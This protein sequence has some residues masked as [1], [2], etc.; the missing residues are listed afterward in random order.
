MESRYTYKFFGPFTVAFETKHDSS[1]FD[2]IWS[3][4]V[5]DWNSLTLWDTNAIRFKLELL[6]L[7]FLTVTLAYFIEEY[8]L[9]MLMFLISCI[10][11]TTSIGPPEAVE[12]RF[13]AVIKRIHQHVHSEDGQMDIWETEK[14]CKLDK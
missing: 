11:F 13:R 10:Q 14:R 7:N 2:K 1:I 8:S 6:M 5:Y 4:L 12:R 9:L 3:A